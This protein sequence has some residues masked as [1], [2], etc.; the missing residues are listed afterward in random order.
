MDHANLGCMADGQPSWVHLIND[1]ALRIHQSLDLNDILQTT[2]DAIHGRLGC[3]RAL[4]YR[5]APNGSGVVVVEAVS[6]P[7]WSL[8]SRVVH[9]AW[10][11][12]NWLEPYHAEG[13]C[14]V[15]DVSTANL[16]PCY[17]ELLAEFQAKAGLAVPILTENQLWGLLMVHHCQ[18]TRRWQMAEIEGLQLLAVQVGIAIH[19]ASLMAQLQ[20][21][22]ATLETAVAERTSELAETNGKLK[23]Q[24]SILQIFYES[25][26]L[27]LGIVETSDDDI[28]HKRHNST[29]LA[30]F[31]I[32]AS[33]LQDRWFSELGVPPDKIQTWLTHFRQ[34]QRSQKPVEFTYAHTTPTAEHRWLSAVVSYV[35]MAE[36]GRPQ[37]SYIAKDVTELQQLD[38][39]R[40]RAREIELQAMQASQERKRLENILE[41]I[42]A[43]Y[44]DWDIAHDQEYLSPGFKQM[45]GYEDP[46][47]PNSP[48]TW[49]NLIFPEDL[50]GVFEQFERHV[51]SHGVEPYYNEV[52]YRHKDGSTVW[53]ICSGKVI[54]WDDAGQPQR[55]IGCHIDITDRKRVEA[56]LRESEARWQ[57]ALEGSGDGVWDWNAATNEV[58]FSHQ[59][60]AMLGYAD[61]EIGN[62]LAE[63]D[64]RLHPDD[65]ARCYEDLQR[66]FAGETPIYQ[67]EHRVLSKDGTY[68]WILDRGKVIEWKP[69]GQPLRVIGTHTDISDRKRA[70][71]ELR[72]TKEQL[73]LV[74]QA[75]SEGFWDWDL[76]T[77]EIY[78]SPRWKEMLGYADHELDNS[79][80]MWESVIF[81]ADRP[82]ALQLIEDY[83]TGKREQFAAIQRFHHKNGSTVYVL[84]R[85]IHL[86]NAAGQVVRM[87]GSH[88]DITQTIRIQEALK[89]S[90]TQLSGIL[91]SSL[92]GI[93]AFRSVRDAQGQIIDFEWLLINPTACDIVGRPAEQLIG[94]RM[95]VEFPGNRDE[96]LF[97][98]YGQVVESGEPARR[99]FYYNHDGIDCWFEA[100]AV[101][102]DDGFTVTFRDITTQ[103]QREKALQSATQAATAANQA[104]SEFLANMSHEIRTPMNAVLGFTELLQQQITD[105][106]SQEYLQAIASSGKT[107]L[108]LINDILDLSKIEAGRLELYPEPISIHA[109]VQDICAIFSHKAIRKGIT[110]NAHLAD[111]LPPYLM[112]D[113]VRLRQILFNVVGNALKFTEVGTINLD[114]AIRRPPASPQQPISLVITV[115]DTGIGIA[116]EQQRRIFAP[117]TQSRGQSNR[118][119]GGT[120]LGLA[121]TRRLVDLM[122]GEI[123]LESELGQGSTFVFTFPQVDI[124]TAD[125]IQVVSDTTD[126]NLSQFAPCRILIVDD[127]ASNRELLAGYLRNT[128]HTYQVAT[129]G[130]EAVR[131]AQT[132]APQLILMDLRMPRMDGLEA[133]RQLKASD[134]TCEIPI[135]IV[136]ASSQAQDEAQLRNICNGFVRKPV[137]LNQLV[138]ALKPLLP[139][140]TAAST[141]TATSEATTVASEAIPQPLTN[142]SPQQQARL[143][144]HLA[145]LETGPW[146]RF[147]NTLTVEHAEAFVVA[148]GQL[149][150][151][152]PY[153]SLVDYAQSL[154]QQLDDFDW[155]RLPNTI[156]DFTSLKRTL[157]SPAPDPP[158][159]H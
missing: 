92:D 47:L 159:P 132:W 89:Q 44:W 95:L 74:L 63:W 93:M 14:A 121:I 82:A 29:T 12:S 102:L 90:E 79:F 76:T 129:N 107:L 109:L 87:V 71:L 69:D 40:Q 130:E 104:K 13:Y 154:R 101:K 34:S 111:D 145:A 156:A 81:A 125:A 56:A 103:Q 150:D 10:V 8:L 11:E 27:I 21:A 131:L 116:P 23:A 96:G 48:Q 138:A 39:E 57:F 65:K 108:A 42:L 151:D 80:A 31:G 62:S 134:K 45:F 20:M 68:R 73:E 25:S 128:H 77:N 38:I 155:E 60:K 115:Q 97:D 70:D 120:G 67:N 17:A 152:I 78:F 114:V 88:L 58:F 146:Q 43:G 153:A 136:T 5:F 84:S 6:A 117:F 55:M 118:K 53:V 140:A 75:S 98:L 1:V 50:P 143:Q 112:V 113:E 148:V 37:F 86:K 141:P 85:A 158:S 15:E 61:H 33:D 137:S 7:P 83:N 66:H 142:L 22:K 126:A 64:S 59:W 123:H 52:R 110:L 124:P 139:R 133:T 100:I 94:Q 28:L 135:V 54:E 30:F 36:S 91:N 147:Q 122:Q 49:Q 157:I 4:V 41:I 46:E 51:Q 149:A 16:P 24:A 35:G 106:Q 72:S 119:Y 26:P 32:E 19:Q 9:T 99:Q 105:R 127:V 2:V 18:A 144:Q 3:D